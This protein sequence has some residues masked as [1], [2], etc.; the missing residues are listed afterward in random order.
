MA[1]IARGAWLLTPEWLYRSVE[2]GAWLPESE[3][4]DLSFPGGKRAR[5]AH[6]VGSAQ[7]LHGLRFA[8]FEPRRANPPVSELRLLITSAGGVVSKKGTGADYSICA[9]GDSASAV[10]ATAKGSTAVTEQW[11]FAALAEYKLPASAAPYAP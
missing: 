5:L 2:A 4:E 1:A 3:F 8:L 7:L 11:L 6:A 9:K 10:T